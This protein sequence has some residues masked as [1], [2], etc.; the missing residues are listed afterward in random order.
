MVS[1]STQITLKKLVQWSVSW[2]H[3]LLPIPRGFTMEEWARY[4]ELEDGLHD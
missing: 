4:E 2:G 3:K 1:V